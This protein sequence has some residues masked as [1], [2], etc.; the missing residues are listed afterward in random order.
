MDFEPDDYLHHHFPRARVIDTDLPGLCQGCVDHDQ[1]IIWLAAD[2]DPVRRRS[3]LTYEIAELRLGPTPENPLLAAAHRRAA[4]E[5]AAHMLISQEAFVAAWGGCLN[6]HEMAARC[7]V[8]LPMFR[9]R[10]RAASDADQDAVMRAITET[11]LT[12]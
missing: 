9:A 7:E 2:L 1:Q 12:A 5:W 10:I 8:D 3:T 4:E 11:R 6:L